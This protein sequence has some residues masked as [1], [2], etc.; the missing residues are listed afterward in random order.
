MMEVAKIVDSREDFEDEELAKLE[1]KAENMEAKAKN[2][3]IREACSL[4]NEIFEEIEKKVFTSSQKTTQCNLYNKFVKIHNEKHS[5]DEAGIYTLKALDFLDRYTPIKL[6]IELFI[7]SAIAFFN[8]NEYAKAKV[9]LET[10]I[11]LC[12]SK[13]FR[14]QFQHLR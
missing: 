13:Q 3:Q 8:K 4:F 12:A 1:E 14:H 7:N 2:G 9:L 10:A 6:K 5:Y 11:A